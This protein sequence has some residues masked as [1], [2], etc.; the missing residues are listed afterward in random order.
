[1]TGSSNNTGLR[2]QP[3]LVYATNLKI[4][5]NQAKKRQKQMPCEARPY[6]LAGH[7]LFWL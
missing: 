7:L 1:M 4:L 3:A 6:C 5:A 2:T